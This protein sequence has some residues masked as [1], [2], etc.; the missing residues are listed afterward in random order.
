MNTQKRNHTIE[1]RFNQEELL[2]IKQKA[3]ALG[4]CVSAFIRLV[5]LKSKVDV[6]D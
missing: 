5:S 3:K 6:S 2:S 4:L 1:I